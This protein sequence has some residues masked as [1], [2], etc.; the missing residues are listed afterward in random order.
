M[1]DNELNAGKK[2][3]RTVPG[4]L[5]L[6]P[7]GARLWADYVCAA[8]G[9]VGRFDFIHKV[10]IP[11][12]FSISVNGQTYN[13]DT[14]SSNWYP[15]QLRMTY[16]DDWIHYEETKFMT[17]EDCAVSCQSW[18]NR[19]DREILLHL[20][21]PTGFAAS[22]AACMQGGYDIPFYSFDIDAC[23]AVSEP[24]LINEGL[25]LAPGETKTF[26]V[27]QSLGIR[28]QDPMDALMNTAAQVISKHT[29]NVE[30]ASSE[31]RKVYQQ[32]FEGTPRFKCNDPLLN[33]TW[34]YRWF[35]L[36]HNLADPRY[37]LLRHPLF[38]EGRSHKKSK[39]PFSKGGWEFSKLI[40]LSVP[41]HMTDAK[42]HHDPSASMGALHNMQDTPAENGMYCCLTADERMHSFANFIGWAAYNLFLIHRNE[43]AILDALPGLKAQ[44]SSWHEVYGNETD[45]LMTEYRHT[46]TG[47][48][49]QPSYWYFHNY[50]RDPKDPETYTH[51]K[52]VDR[53]VYHYLNV[54]GVAR[55]CEMVGDSESE[56]YLQLAERIKNDVLAKMW[57]EST[58]FFYD[59]HYQTDEKALVKNIVGFYPAWADMLDSRHDRLVKHLLDPNEFATDCRYPSVSADSAAYAKEGGWFGRFVKG[60]NGCMWNGPAWPYTNSIALDALAHESKR[61]HHAYDSKFAK[62]LREYSFL[63]FQDRDLTRPCLVEHYNSATGEPLSDEQEYNHSYYID[64]I[65]SHVVGLSISADRLSLDPLDIGLDYFELDQVKAA[66]QDIRITYG[67]PGLSR[68]PDGIEAGYRLYLNGELVNTQD[69]LTSVHLPLAI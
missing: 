25:K 38:Y 59:L 45:G 54:I 30:K 46:R 6:G 9:F 58:A 3:L 18:T 61:N 64:L 50:P 13:M 7:T 24:L 12:L 69:R 42:W 51:V 17:W 62:D 49:Y 29:D 21:V 52:R 2:A 57:D 66:G 41:L 33:K 15:S 20:I 56:K 63:H 27:A 40:N 4:G 28:S 55:L 36:R 23:I 19:S 39:R 11:L 44:V 35:L 32:W 65:I 5:L 10:N 8:P 26:I 1:I 43:T 67:K 47:K 14:A 37:G 16:A 48:E 53:T 31:Q 22:S 68:Y 34:S 60:R